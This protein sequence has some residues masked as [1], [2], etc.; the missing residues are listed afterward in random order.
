MHLD[1]WYC[2]E[3]GCKDMIFILR[4]CSVLELL[5]LIHTRVLRW[6]RNYA[7]MI[8]GDEDANVANAD[9]PDPT[10]PSSPAHDA[11]GITLLI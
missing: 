3:C 6:H 4:L 8:S 2:E 10:G 11:Q 1:E 5:A 9:I 7:V